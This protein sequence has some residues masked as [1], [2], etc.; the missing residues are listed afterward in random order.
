MLRAEIDPDPQACLT[1][2]RRKEAL[3]VQSHPH[4]NEWEAPSFSN[5][6]INL[7]IHEDLSTSQV[8]L[9]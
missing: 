8:T 1:L 9:L 2:M 6:W 7:F 5:P 4:G 3:F